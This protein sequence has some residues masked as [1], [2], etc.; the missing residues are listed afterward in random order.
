MESNQTNTLSQ[1]QFML[2]KLNDHI[3]Q[4]N[5]IILEIN[6]MI[7]QF[8]ISSQNSMNDFAQIINN[9]FKLNMNLNPFFN[10]LVRQ[11][12]PKQKVNV[13]FELKG[14]QNIFNK[15]KFNLIL[16]SDIPINEALRLFLKKIDREDCINNDK[17]YFF[18]NGKKIDFN[19]KRKIKELNSLPISYFVITVC[20]NESFL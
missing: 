13:S 10:N 16:E 14:I 12:I 5:S 19:D 6:N 15:D 18:Y 3:F 20:N 1:L 4:I 17:L 7:N 11:D 2:T 8:N 9:P